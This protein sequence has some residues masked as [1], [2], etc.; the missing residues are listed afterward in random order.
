MLIKVI[1]GGATPGGRVSQPEYDV[2]YTQVYNNH[3]AAIPAGSHVCFDPSATT[4]QNLG[5]AVTRPATANLVFYAGC[6]PF[7]IPLGAWGLC[8]CYGIVEKMAQDGGTTDT[9]IGNT[10]T[11]ANGTFVPHTPVAGTQGSGWITSM[12][13]VTTQTGLGRGMIRAM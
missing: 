9:A 7:G 12:E 2:V 1:G 11:L 10:F 3:T 6:T 4:A 8:V 5:W 13:V